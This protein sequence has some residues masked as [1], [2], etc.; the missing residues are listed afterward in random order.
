MGNRSTAEGRHVARTARDRA[1]REARRRARLYTARRV[2]HEQR[3][4]RRRRDD[5]IAP[6]VF[7]VVIALATTTQVL[8]FT[9]G[10][11]KPVAKPKAT[12]SATATPTPTA[13]VP[14]KALSQNRTWTGS[15]TLNSVKLGITLDGKRAPQA[16]ANFVSLTQKGFYTGLTCHRLTTAQLYVLQCGDPKGDGTGGPGY[17]FGPIENAPKDG[18]YP[19]ADL[20]M[21]NS[22]SAT[23]QGSQFFLVYRTSTLGVTP[24]YTVFGH[25]TSG[26]PA[27]QSAVISKGVASSSAD[28]TDGPPA[29]ATRITALSVH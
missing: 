28:R 3:V 18:V 11:G 21:A 6:I 1:D 25:V 5:V 24:G 22:G 8:W 23:S 12:T 17:S 27:L 10:P 16:V 2:V 14:P 26:L 19:T 29:V 9:A 13:T 4:R 15:M 20:A 7:L